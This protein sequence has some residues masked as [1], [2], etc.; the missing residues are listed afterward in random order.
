MVKGYFSASKNIGFTHKE[1]WDNFLKILNITAKVYW[2][3][4][5]EKKDY[6]KNG[7]CFQMSVLRFCS[8]DNQ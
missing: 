4:L 2:D 7:K 5:V 6:N 3:K 8:L 1:K